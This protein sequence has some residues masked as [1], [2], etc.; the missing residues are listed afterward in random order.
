MNAFSPK[1]EGFYRQHGGRTLPSIDQAIEDGAAWQPE[2]LTPAGYVVLDNAALWASGTTEAEAWAAAFEIML[3]VGIRVVDDGSVLVGQA[4]DC[5]P[6]S[7]FQVRK[8]TTAVMRQLATVG[9]QLSWGMVG[10]VCCTMAERAAWEMRLM[11]GE[12]GWA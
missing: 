1:A 9:D 7:T 8:A 3:D 12:G 6:A 4:L 11:D 10:A 2:A 5:I